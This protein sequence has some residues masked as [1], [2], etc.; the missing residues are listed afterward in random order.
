[1]EQSSF[2]EQF[3]Q[4]KSHSVIYW[5]AEESSKRTFE[6]LIAPDDTP[7]NILPS[8]KEDED[9]LGLAFHALISVSWLSVRD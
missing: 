4:Q 6:S 3:L 1:M 5:V 2:G 7:E 9:W 8:I